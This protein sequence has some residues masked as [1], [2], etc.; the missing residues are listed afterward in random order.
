[1]GCAHVCAQARD[2]LGDGIPPHVRLVPLSGS[3]P[4][5]VLECL[6][7]HRRSEQEVGAP[8]AAAAAT[9]AAT[10]AT[11]MT[12]SVPP[13]HERGVSVAFLQAFAVAMPVNRTTR[14]VVASLVVPSTG[15]STPLPAA[16]LFSELAMQLENGTARHPVCG[17]P[18]FF[19]SHPWDQPF[20]D[21]VS[22]VV[23]YCSNHNIDPNQCFV[24]IDVLCLNQHSELPGSLEALACPQ[25]TKIHLLL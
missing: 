21:T 9:T 17:A 6:E 24:W 1:M 2:K 15:G 22:A 11:A 19:I 12:R 16:A 7:R 5:S 14:D 3:K 8:A 4:L 10:A 23:Q 18:R 20:A 13:P 25:H